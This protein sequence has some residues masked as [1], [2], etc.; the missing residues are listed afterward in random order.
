M[1][2]IV[3]QI[4]KEV[5]MKL[6]SE[7]ANRGSA[8]SP[9]PQRQV[10]SLPDSKLLSEKS[11]VLLT[12]NLKLIDQVVGQIKSI[13][14]ANSKVIVSSYVYKNF[15]APALQ[16][17]FKL[18]HADNT[19]AHLALQDVQHLIIPSMS[20]NSLAKSAALIAD[21]FATIVLTQA[22]M[23]GIKI[24]IADEA[25]IDSNRYYPAGVAKKIDNYRRELEAMGVIFHKIPGMHVTP[26]FKCSDCAA[27]NCASCTTCS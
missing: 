6:K 10:S 8:Y 24:T 14:P 20:I 16:N 18:I 25:I 12:A 17:D 13:I 9:T 26:T 15:N 19:A 2:A 21:S 22:L 5:M 7:S 3:E 11:A 1:E 23:D 4:A 27:G